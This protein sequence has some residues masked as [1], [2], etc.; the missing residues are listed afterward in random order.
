LIF[1]GIIDAG[2]Q[3]SFISVKAEPAERISPFGGANRDS[4][5]LQPVR[6]S[7]HSNM[8]TLR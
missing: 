6:S 3:P 1:A 7:S 8:Q 2:N 5:N 4:F